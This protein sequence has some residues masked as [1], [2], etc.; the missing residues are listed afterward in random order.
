MEFT[1]SAANAILTVM[2]KNNLDPKDFILLFE[3]MDNGTL[4]FTFSKD[5]IHSRV[6]H[7]LRVKINSDVG[8]DNTVVDF[9]EVA[10]RRGIIFLEKQK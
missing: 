7:G 5:K 2:K 1:Q 9:G 10:G 8:M 3:R 4:G 6:F